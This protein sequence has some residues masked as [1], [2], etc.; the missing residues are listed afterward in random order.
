M[1]ERAAPALL[2]AG[3]RLI[4]QRMPSGPLVVALLLVPVVPVVA[5]LPHVVAWI[6]VEPRSHSV[7]CTS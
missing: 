4:A 3:E 1:N 5:R 7:R 6:T 2:T